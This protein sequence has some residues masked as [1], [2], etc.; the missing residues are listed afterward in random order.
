MK[1][2][3]NRIVQ[4]LASFSVSAVVATT[5]VADERLTGLDDYVAALMDLSHVPGVA[6]TIVE[7][8]RVAIKGFGVRTA[9][10][11]DPI[12]GD[13]VFAIGSM[14]KNITATALAIAVEKGD[15]SW[16][17]PLTHYVDGLAFSD[18]YLN[19][20]LTLRDALSHRTGLDRA[21]LI[22]FA[23]KG[24]TRADMVSRIRNIPRIEAFRDSYLYNNFMYLA[25]G[26][27]IPAVTGVSWDAYLNEH[28]F[29]P[30]GMTRTTTNV[31]AL[32][33]MANV[34]TPHY[35]KPERA[36][37][38]E[39]FDLAHM[40][41]AGSVNSTANDMATWCRMQID[42]GSHSGKQVVPTAALNAVR[43][44]LTFME[45]A[46]KGHIG[47][48]HKAYAM[49]LERMNYG[50]GHVVYSHGGAIQGMASL[51]SFIPDADLCVA[52]L[53]NGETGSGVRQ[54]VSDW[55]MDH[56]LGIPKTDYLS[57]FNAN[58]MK[59]RGRNAGAAQLHAAT[60]APSTGY[61]VNATAVVG[62]YSN[63]VYG[64]L[65]ISEK[66]GT[67]HTLYGTAFKGTLSPHRGYT[68]DITPEDSVR[69]AASPAPLNLS[70]AF[71]KSG[72]V[73][74]VLLQMPG[75][76]T[77]GIRF[78]PVGNDKPQQ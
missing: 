53:T 12:D 19:E 23:R 21:D 63:P 16:D 13:T 69:A 57:D 43:T 75:P 68:F 41:P 17:T 1:K 30:L 32:E 44:P 72:K 37:P 22:W 76:S 40:G 26:E 14:T 27:A 66:E 11:E 9:G 15:L 59:R 33:G 2:H 55:V 74:S 20:Q 61:E 25:A 47:T 58:L 29:T 49:G 77:S 3:T 65:T 45:H 60:H 39:Y 6:L 31:A 4:L 62:I 67:L 54:F 52:V 70:F 24:A 36:V 73:S 71:E 18:P 38:T 56:L 48:Q 35:L 28:L 7:G 34:A 78:E 51:I 50:D 10:A 8:D 46:E 5:S 42:G 64:E